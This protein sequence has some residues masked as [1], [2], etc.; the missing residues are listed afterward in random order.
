MTM[1]EVTQEV[2][3][4]WGE[5][6]VTVRPGESIVFEGTVAGV[7]PTVEATFYADGDGVYRFEEGSIEAPAAHPQSKSLVVR[8]V[9][10]TLIDAGWNIDPE[11]AP[12][13]YERRED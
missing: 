3:E 6:E 5:G 9:E 2:D 8:H 13:D 11:V 4:T 1:S 10:Q 7:I 12:D